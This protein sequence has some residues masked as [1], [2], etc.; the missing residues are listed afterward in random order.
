MKVLV[1]GAKG[2]IGRN[3]IV[4]L[5]RRPG[6]ELLTF[7]IDTGQEQLQKQLCAADAVFHLAGVNRPERLEDYD[8]GN[9]ALTA[10]VCDMLEVAG[11]A[12]LVVL[13]S[14]T[15]A[16]L[17]NPYGRSKRA[18]E[19]AVLAFARTSGARVRVFRLPGVFG[20]WCRPNYNS[21]VATFCHSVARGV[22]IAVSDPARV[23]DLVHVDDVVRT[24]LA[25][26]DG[27]EPST[28][29]GY[30]RV[31]P[32]HHIRLSDLAERIQRFG[33]SRRTLEV[34]DFADELTRLLHSTYLSYLPEGE[35]A[36]ALK[37]R[38]DARGELAELLRSSHFGQIFVSRTRTGI[39]RGNHYHDAKV[40]KFVVV[41]GE[42][43]LRF[44]SIVDGKVT[45]YS[46]SGRDFVVVDIP[47][48]YTHHIEIVDRSRS[49]PAARTNV[50][51][52]CRTPMFP[53]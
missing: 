53:A 14:S 18:A 21:V 22:P 51:R 20:K 8:E 17:E 16:A 34:P 9:A 49:L 37:Q 23:L 10:R 27:G 44:R 43:K 13:S 29:G 32:V 1:T 36:Y 46:V 19:Q 26:L 11:R 38:V 31:E 5:G 50:S 35:F 12:P 6:V 3:L 41:E 4:A 42:A 33:D 28:E 25:V 48:G 24:F 30:C 39:T 45:E 40:E 15:Q 7:D 2:F 52:P 47:P